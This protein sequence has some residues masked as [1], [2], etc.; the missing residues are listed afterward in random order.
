MIT[1][2]SGSDNQNA[3][4]EAGEYFAMI[5]KAEVIN[6]KRGEKLKITFV[7]E[8]GRMREE[9]V[10]PATWIALFTDLLEASGQEFGSEGE[11]DEQALVGVEGTLRMS[12]VQGKGE[13]AG[14]TF[15]NAERFITD[16]PEEEVKKND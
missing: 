15:I 6:T 10:M 8:D 7:L 16:K 12:E 2:T 11:F 9:W 1:Y 4:L 3:Q 14:K 13:N 5:S